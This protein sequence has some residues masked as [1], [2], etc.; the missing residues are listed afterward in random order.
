[1]WSHFWITLEITEPF[2]GLGRVR[3]SIHEKKEGNIMLWSSGDSAL[4][5]RCFEELSELTNLSHEKVMLRFVQTCNF[6]SNFAVLN[7]KF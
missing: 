4:A 7:V 5:G 3:V 6:A 2:V 1:M